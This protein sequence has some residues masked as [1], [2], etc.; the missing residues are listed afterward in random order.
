MVAEETI[1]YYSMVA[2]VK[3]LQLGPRLLKYYRFLQQ[4]L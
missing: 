2:E 3:W 1:G 4:E